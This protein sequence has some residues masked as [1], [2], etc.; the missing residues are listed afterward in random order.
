M[1]TFRKRYGANVSG[2]PLWMGLLDVSQRL[3]RCFINLKDHLYNEISLILQR[4]IFLYG[5]RAFLAG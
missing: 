4:L 3:L 1:S 2:R 5:K